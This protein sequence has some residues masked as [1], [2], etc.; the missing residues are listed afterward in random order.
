[1][2]LAKKP[3]TALSQ[4]AEVVRRK[5]LL[6][7]FAAYAVVVRCNK[8]PVFLLGCVL[9]HHALRATGATRAAAWC[10]HGDCLGAIVISTAASG[11]R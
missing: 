7:T 6:K 2:G 11:P 1:M 3:S 4:D 5:F 10:R 9:S 8:R